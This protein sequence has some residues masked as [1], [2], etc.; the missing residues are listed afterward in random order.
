MQFIKGGFSHRV[1][2]EL[3]TRMEIWQ[4]GFSDH[5]IRDFEDFEKHRAYVHQNPVKARL[6]LAAKDYKYS[7]AFGLFELD[8]IPQRLKP[9]VLAN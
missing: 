2:V 8:P 3:Q 4:K 7:S 1:T 9:G 5:R 6:A